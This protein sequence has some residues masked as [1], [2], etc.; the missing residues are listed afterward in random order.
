[1]GRLHGKRTG[2]VLSADILQSSSV[3]GRCVR[4]QVDFTGAALWSSRTKCFPRPLAAA[5]CPAVSAAAMPD[6]YAEQAYLYFVNPPSSVLLAPFAARAHS[7]RRHPLHQTLFFVS[8]ST[9][10]YL[11][12]PPLPP[13]SLVAPRS[14]LV[15]PQLRR[16][17]AAGAELDGH[18]Q[19]DVGQAHR[20]G[21]GSARGGGDVRPAGR[22]GGEVGR[23]LPRKGIP[24]PWLQLW[25]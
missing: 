15:S 2:S 16:E 3:I 18:R 6:P 17:Q 25:P 22:G 1:M 14:P 8:L 7:F 11:R 12:P 19:G 13:T 21:R 4:C 24:T 9:P 23:L 10:L 20:G 5:V